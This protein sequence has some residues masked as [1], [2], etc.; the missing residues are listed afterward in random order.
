MSVVR[1]LKSYNI[2]STRQRAEVLAGVIS[3]K[4]RHFSSEDVLSFLTQKKRKV[5]RA[6]TFRTLR[7]FSKKGLLRSLDLGKGWAIYEVAVDSPHH[8]HLYCI[9]CGKIIEFEE[10]QIERLQDK[11]CRKRN[12][13]SL[14]HT[15]RIVGFCR[16][17]QK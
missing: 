4:Q 2:R 16:E 5:S 10:H 1:L 3:F 9:K 17:C 6:T 12:F 13:R 7:L 14:G 8:D 15:L 11:A